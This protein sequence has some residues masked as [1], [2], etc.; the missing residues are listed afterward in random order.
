MNNTENV[1]R[2]KAHMSKNEDI[3]WAHVLLVE[4]NSAAAMGGELLLK[5]LHCSVDIASK[6]SQAIK[7]AQIKAYDLILMDIGLP[8]FDGLEVVRIIR[9]FPDI[10]KAQVPIVALTGHAGDAKKEQSYIDLKIQAVLNKPI[11]LL[12]L[13]SILNQLKNKV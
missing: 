11:Q 9:T 5:R 3:G 8:D 6:G 7:Y 1:L 4:D 12:I 10:K 2:T 13:K